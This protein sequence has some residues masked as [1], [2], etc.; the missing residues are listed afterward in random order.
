MT[1][2]KQL[3]ILI[4]AIF[5][6]LISI[7]FAISVENFKSYLEDEGQIHSQD[8]ATSLGLSLSPYMNDTSDPII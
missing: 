1:L 8:T 5:L 2:S 4:S 6:I 7:N 3:L